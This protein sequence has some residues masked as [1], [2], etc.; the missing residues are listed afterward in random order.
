MNSFSWPTTPMSRATSSPP[1]C[2]TCNP[3]LQL[4]GL[5]LMP[6]PAFDRSRLRLQPLNQRK[7]DLDLSV[8]L[9]LNAPLTKFTHP[10]LPKLGHCLAEAHRRGAARSMLVSAHVLRA[11]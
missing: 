4:E 10:A 5:R 3:I 2:P 9:S 8:M 6:Y 11:G 1:K 7:H